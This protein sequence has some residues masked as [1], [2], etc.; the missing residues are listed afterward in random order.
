M[1]RKYIGCHSA[2]EAEGKVEFFNEYLGKYDLVI[3]FLH[4]EDMLMYFDRYGNENRTY[5]YRP[6]NWETG[7]F[8]DWQVCESNWG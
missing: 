3:Y 7:R 5:Y 1:T 2:S 4:E 6:M 8:G